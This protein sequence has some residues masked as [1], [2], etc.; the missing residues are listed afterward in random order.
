MLKTRVIPTILFKESGAV[1][2]KNFSNDR[3]IGSILTA[4]KIYNARDVDEIILLDVEAT[5]RKLPPNLEMLK[6][7]SEHCFVPLAFGGGINNIEQVRQI[8]KNG[9]DK[10]VVN[11]YSYKNQKFISEL[12]NL[13]GSQSI[14]ASVD[15]KREEGEWVCYGNSGSLRKSFNVKDWIKILEELGAGELII[16]S[17][18]NDGIMSGYDLDLIKF[19]STNTN[20]PVIASGGAKN[21]D[22]FVNAVKHSGASAVSASS[23]FQF[24]QSTPLEAK[25]YMQSH[26]ISVRT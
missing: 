23:I 14:V 8:F 25:Q 19:V 12:S 21:Y 22:D 13:F 4:I 15:V 1:K 9:A 24:T 26:G 20:L 11:S 6:E 7:V 5:N 17:I 3:I 2:G 10:I 18:D 16:T